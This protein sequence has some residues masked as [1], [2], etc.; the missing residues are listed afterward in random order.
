MK[1]HN[2][3]LGRLKLDIETL[4]NLQVVELEGVVG[5]LNERASLSVGCNCET[6]SYN[7][8]R[9]ACPQ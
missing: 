5:G 8:S 6:D 7:C 4:R 9:K 2:G 3:L 1:T